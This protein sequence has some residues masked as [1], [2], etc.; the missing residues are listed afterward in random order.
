MKKL[1]LILFLLPLMAMAQIRTHVV[2]AK[3][4]FSSI[5]RLYD[6]NGRTLAEFNKLDY[7]GGISIG[8]VLKIPKSTGNE[9]IDKPVSEI[10]KSTPAAVGTGQPIFHTVLAKETLY[11]ISKL[12][13]QATIDR[14]RLWNNLPGNDVSEGAQLIVGYTNANPVKTSTTPKPEVKNT[15][16]IPEK[17]VVKTVVKEKDKIEEI[18]EDDE[19]NTEMAVGGTG[20]YFSK[21]Y[22]GNSGEQQKGKAG[23]FKSTSGWEDSKYYCLHNSARAGTIIK[24]I[25]PANDKYVYA[26]VLDVIPDISQNKDVILRLSN[27]AADVLGVSGSQFTC[28]VEF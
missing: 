20:G 24:V 15:S 7:E 16:A 13:P 9:T 21:N 22:D 3:E 10:V 5:G 17:P 12:Y 28:K 23:I 1:L 26:K 19:P 4:S 6:V 27:S 11:A 18:K 25:N 8:Q 2:K 14:I